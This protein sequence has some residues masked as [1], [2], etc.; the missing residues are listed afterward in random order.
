[1]ESRLDLE[2]F[3]KRIKEARAT[4]AKEYMDPIISIQ[5]LGRALDVSKEN[6]GQQIGRTIN[7]DGSKG[8]FIDITNNME[9][10]KVEYEGR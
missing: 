10:G 9:D 5:Q 1:M 8:F 3:A 4:G 2:K 6:L 7:N